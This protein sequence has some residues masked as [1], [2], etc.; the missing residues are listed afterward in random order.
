M[1]TMEEYASFLAELVAG[2]RVGELGMQ[3]NVLIIREKNL[4]EAEYVTLFTSVWEK[5]KERDAEERQAVLIPHTYLSAA[6][7]TGSL[8]IH[9]PLLLLQKYREMGELAQMQEVGV[10]VH[11]VDEAKQ[12]EELGASYITAGHIY[13]TDCKRGVP[14]RGM[15]FLEQVCESVKIPVY[16]IGG[17]H[18]ENLSKIQVSSAAGACMMSEYMISRYH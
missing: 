8:R 14:P 15:E 12:A 16:A 11:S 6:V 18:E 4:A 9:L 3:P 5:C 17:I 2:T 1:G 7:Q 10:S 13:P